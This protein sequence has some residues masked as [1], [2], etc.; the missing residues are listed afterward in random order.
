VTIIIIII[1]IIIIT[2]LQ[3]R[4]RNTTLC[5]A[6]EALLQGLFPLM[7]AESSIVLRDDIFAQFSAAVVNYCCKRGP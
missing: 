1:I 3:H 5:I 6:H 2:I 4:D 7:S